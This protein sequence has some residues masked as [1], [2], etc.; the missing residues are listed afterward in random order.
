MADGFVARLSD[1]AR[2]QRSAIV[3]SAFGAAVFIAS[4][5]ATF[6]YAATLTALLQPLSL[7]FTSSGQGFSLPLGAALSDVRVVS[8]EPASAFEIESPDV[9]LTPALGALLL[10]EPGVRVHAQLYGGTLSATVYRKGAKVG[11][12]FSLSDMGLARLAAL[13]ALG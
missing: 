9:T 6:P 8:L 7:G 2:E 12:S 4:L 3:Y 13:R 11:V 5:G 1:F 10:G